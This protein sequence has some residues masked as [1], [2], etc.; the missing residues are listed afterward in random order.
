MS[1]ANI[2]FDMDRLKNNTASVRTAMSVMKTI[3]HGGNDKKRLKAF[4]SLNKVRDS[5][6]PTNRLLKGIIKKNSG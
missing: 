3:S 6:F 1:D 4:K 5:I 2:Y